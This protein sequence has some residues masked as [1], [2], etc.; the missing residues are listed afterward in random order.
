MTNIIYSIS[1]NSLSLKNLEYTWDE[2]EYTS[3]EE[4]FDIPG[5]FIEIEERNNE[6]L[7]ASHDSGLFDSLF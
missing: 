6:K 5:E 7:D 1:L 4:D 2:L 3:D